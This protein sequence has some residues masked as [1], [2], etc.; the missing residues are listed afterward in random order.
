MKKRWLLLAGLALF[1]GIS[2][3][4]AVAREMGKLGSDLEEASRETERELIL[5]AHDEPEITGL[6]AP[7]SSMSADWGA[8]DLDGWWH[9][10]IPEAYKRTGGYLPDLVQ[11]YLYCLCKRDGLDYPM[12]LAMIEVESGYR[13]DVAASGGGIGYLQVVYSAHADRI[14]GAGEEV[15]TNPYTNIRVALEYLKELSDRFD[16]R[17]KVLTAY[18]YGV[19]GAYRNFWNAGK[20]TSPYADHVLEVRERIAEE[21]DVRKTEAQIEAMEWQAGKEEKDGNK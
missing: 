11:V 7:F 15:L 13:Y 3:L 18:S 9:Y 10:E 12:V 6:A 8:G 17:E 16:T 4:W 14:P 5:P 21:L 2:F 19:T 1:A 20:D